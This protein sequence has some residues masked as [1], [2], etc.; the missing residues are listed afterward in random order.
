MNTA[1]INK[2]V[3]NF[4]KLTINKLMDNYMV[5]FVKKHGFVRGFVETWC[6]A[7]LQAEHNR[8]QKKQRA[9]VCP[10]LYR[11]CV[12]CW[13]CWILEIPAAETAIVIV[14]AA[15]WIP[16][17]NTA[18]VVA[19]CGCRCRKSFLGT[20]FY[21]LHSGFCIYFFHFSLYVFLLWFN[22]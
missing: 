15:A 22:F 7:S 12:V 1:K 10:L 11:I 8:Q 13:G 5:I 17:D 2:F 3:N 9:Q 16:A 21:N 6:T 4:H 18:I 14:V 20:E 19:L